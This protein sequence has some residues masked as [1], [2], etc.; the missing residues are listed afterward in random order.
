M[1]KTYVIA[2]IGINYNGSIENCYKL[3]DIAK[4]TGCDA[5]KFQVFSAKNLYPKSAGQLDWKDND[6]EYSYDIYDA[7][8][9][10]ELP[11]EWIDQLMKY[12]SQKEID[13]MSSI[14]DEEGLNIMIQ[15]GIKTIKLSSYTI[16]H[17]PL[18]EAVAKTGLP[19]FM[20][21]G[22]ATLSE[23]EA[24]IKT[25]Q[26]YHNKLTILHCSIQYPTNLEDVNMGI[27][28]TF[29]VAFPNIQTGYSDH[30]KEVS[31]A[32]IQAIYLGANVIEKHITLDKTMEGPDHFFALEPQELKQM[33]KDIKE[34]KEKFLKNIYK[35]N[36]SIYGNSEKLCHKNEKYLRDFCY[37][38]MY[39][40]KRFK[41]NEIIYPTD[42]AILRPGK[43]DPGLEPKYLKLFHNT[44]IT[45]SKDINIE[46]PIT[47]EVI[48]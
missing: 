39:S 11:I 45:A 42:I 6:K 10:F 25:V 14:F 47:W 5:A 40:K 9:K 48:L 32:A 4:D 44:T 15:K 31:E 33:V 20:S 13:F 29:R 22:G 26:K 37:M 3:I 28:E 46:D 35:I 41:K 34:A 12:C 18:I 23:V 17:I 19:I 24:A 2:E 30:T 7:V 16:T 21:T 8:K 43:K 1:D 38:T 36:P 27:L